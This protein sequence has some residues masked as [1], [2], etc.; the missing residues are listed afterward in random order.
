MLFF[1]VS[2]NR[3]VVYNWLMPNSILNS[4]HEGHSSQAAGHPNP[5][6]QK[7]RKIRLE[8]C[9]TKVTFLASLVIQMADFA[10]DIFAPNELLVGAER[11]ILI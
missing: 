1:T 4:D 11:F 2:V 8:P 7:K 6:K 10:P 5:I 3:N 9:V